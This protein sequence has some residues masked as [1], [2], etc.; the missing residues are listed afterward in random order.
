M[1]Q[2]YSIL[3]K[4]AFATVQK[5]PANKACR[6]GETERKSSLNKMKIR[7]SRRD[8]MPAVFADK[9]CSFFSV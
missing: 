8:S 6:M 1:A 5:V 7:A 9:Q 4:Q 2:R 3:S